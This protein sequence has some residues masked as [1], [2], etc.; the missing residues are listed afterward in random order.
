MLFISVSVSTDY[1]L[2]WNC[3]IWEEKRKKTKRDRAT[4]VA[5]EEQESSYLGYMLFRKKSISI[6]FSSLVNNENILSSEFHNIRNTFDKILI[7]KIRKNIHAIA[8]LYFM[9]IYMSLQN[10]KKNILT[11]MRHR[12]VYNELKGI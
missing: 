8:I 10:L 12:I 11:S 3:L 7:L 1:I 2:I 6:C 4:A 9:Y 5:T